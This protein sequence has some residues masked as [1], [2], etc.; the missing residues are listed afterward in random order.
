M[1]GKKMP[2]HMGDCRVT[3]QNLKVIDVRGDTNV[4]LIEGA[5]PGPTKGY[6]VIEKAVKKQKK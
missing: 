3:V 5:V 4:L 1:K 6:V 2:G